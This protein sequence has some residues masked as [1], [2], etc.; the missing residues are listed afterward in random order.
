MEAH[1]HAGQARCRQAG[2]AGV[3]EVG[4]QDRGPVTA[5]PAVDARREAP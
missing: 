2:Q 4:V 5:A 1:G 3:G